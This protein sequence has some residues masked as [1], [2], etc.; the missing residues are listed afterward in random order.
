MIQLTGSAGCYRVKGHEHIMVM[1]QKGRSWNGR[2]GAIAVTN[3]YAFDTSKRREDAPAHDCIIKDGV[4]VKP[5]VDVCK[6]HRTLAG[7]RKQLSKILEAA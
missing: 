5:Y 6:S 1:V 4:L 3:W 2:E 7:L